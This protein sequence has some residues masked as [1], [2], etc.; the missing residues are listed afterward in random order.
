[1]L[2]PVRLY[3]RRNRWCPRRSRGGRHRL[4]SASQP[5]RNQRHEEF[6]IKQQKSENQ[7]DVIQEGIIA[8]QDDANLPGRDEKERSNSPGPRKKHGED[9]YQFESER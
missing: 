2:P 9:Q 1:M 7:N 6:V 8:G 5:L 4:C 3:L